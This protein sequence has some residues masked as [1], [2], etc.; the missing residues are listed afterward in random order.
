MEERVR[1]MLVQNESK[2]S[3][4]SRLDCCAFCNKA[5]FWS[6]T[7]ALGIIDYKKR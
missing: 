2:N 5:P 7:K 4:V 3:Q 6:H 1:K